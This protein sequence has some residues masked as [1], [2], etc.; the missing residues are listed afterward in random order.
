MPERTWLCIGDIV[1]AQSKISDPWWPGLVVRIQPTQ[2]SILWFPDGERAKVGWDNVT[3]FIPTHPYLTG[4]EKSKGQ[5]RAI[6][7]A[8]DEFSIRIQHEAQQIQLHSD[9]CFRC[10]EQGKVILCDWCPNAWHEGC[11]PKRI[12]PPEVDA[13]WCCPSCQ[14][15]TSFETSVCKVAISTPLPPCYPRRITAGL[16]VALKR[17]RVELPKAIEIEH[18]FGPVITAAR[19]EMPPRLL[20]FLTTELAG[21]TAKPFPRPITVNFILNEFAE[22]LRLMDALGNQGA[23]EVAMLGLRDTFLNALPCLLYPE[24]RSFAAEGADVRLNNLLI[25]GA[26][27]LLRLVVL[28]PPT[29]CAAKGMRDAN[30]AVAFLNLLLCYLDGNFHRLFIQPS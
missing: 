29:V 9:R 8:L 18:A 24:E 10:E 4:L 1:M 14:K 20:S 13:P 16:K 2:L 3:H 27:H 23:R 22:N 28:L 30:Y 5:K 6:E 26:E 21:R 7:A 19:L 11:L 25:F 17:Q 12:N 15:S